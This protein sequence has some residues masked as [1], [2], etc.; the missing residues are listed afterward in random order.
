MR[1]DPHSPWLRDIGD[2]FLRGIY[3][4]ALRRDPEDPEALDF[5]A[6]HYTRAG[7]IAEGL[8]LDRRLVALRP[9]DP[10][11]RYNLACSLA[12]SG[13]RD[14]AIAAL[15][16]AV[17]RGYREA[18]HARADEDLA[19]LR[20]DRRFEDLLDGMSATGPGRAAEEE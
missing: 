16:D 6:H 13:E 4:E 19:A 20:G 10:V 15:R 3:E 8:A 9:E 12:L 11:A 7:R 5:L 1:I 17:R 2:A 14:Q 18:D